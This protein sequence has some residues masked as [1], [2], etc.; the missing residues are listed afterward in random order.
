MTPA[1]ASERSIFSKKITIVIAIYR[2]SFPCRGEHVRTSISRCRC[3]RWQKTIH[4][5]TQ[6]HTRDSHSDDNWRASEASEPLS[7]HVN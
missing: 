6:T 4:E 1:V 3:T 2:E 5:Q 7:Y